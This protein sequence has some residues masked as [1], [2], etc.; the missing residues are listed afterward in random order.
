MIFVFSFLMSDSVIIYGVRFKKHYKTV[1]L[2]SPLC[3]RFV[4]NPE[5]LWYFKAAKRYTLKR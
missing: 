4:D 5:K 3:K 2:K 1:P